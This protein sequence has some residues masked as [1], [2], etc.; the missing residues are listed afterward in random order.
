MSKLELMKRFMNTFVRNDLHLIIKDK[1]RFYVHTIEVFQKTDDSCPIKGIPIGDYFLRLSAKD[2]DNR[3][4][5]IL[6]S[7]SEQLIQNLLEHAVYAREAGY[8]AITMV[9]SP[10]AENDWLL[11]WGDKQDL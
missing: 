9:R 3:E 8:K 7:W 1:N 11:M 6:C 2:E 4:A 10:L 5:S